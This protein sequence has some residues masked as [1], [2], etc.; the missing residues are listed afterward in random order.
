MTSRALLEI[1]RDRPELHAIFAYVRVR[2][3]RAQFSAAAHVR[4]CI[5]RALSCPETACMPRVQWTIGEVSGIIMN[6][7]MH[8][9]KRREEYTSLSN[10]I[11]V[12]MP[13]SVC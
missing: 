8:L 13:T 10:Y 7:D 11:Q 3:C 12:A 6:A 1:V 9:V 2:S 5:V 4:C